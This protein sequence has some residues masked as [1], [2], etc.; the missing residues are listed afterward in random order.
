MALRRLL[1]PF[2][3]GS[4]RWLAAISLCAWLGLLATEVL[5][6]GDLHRHHPAMH[7][8]AGASGFGFLT[9]WSIMLIGMAPLLLRG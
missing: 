3:R 2:G 5:T 9:G 6:A 7:G 1:T 4:G 8:N